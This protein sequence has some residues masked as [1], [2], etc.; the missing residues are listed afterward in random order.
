MVV[1]IIQLYLVCP[2]IT[3]NAE[4]SFSQLRRIKTYSRSTMNQ[5]RLNGLL[6]LSTYH[7]ELDS[8]NIYE[9]AND[10]VMRIETRRAVFSFNNYYHRNKN[11]CVIVLFLGIV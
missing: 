9:L 8:L 10:F 1:N 3:A 5:R 7:E 6:I 2:T 4:R 11:V